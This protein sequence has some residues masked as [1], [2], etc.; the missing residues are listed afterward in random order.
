LASPVR[1]SFLPV[2]EAPDARVSRIYNIRDLPGDPVAKTPCSQ[3]K[4][5]GF[6]SWSGTRPHVQQLEFL[7]VE[8]KIEDP[9]GCDEDQAQPNK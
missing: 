3:C 7:N 1:G 9:I 8:M 2:S 4:G 5:P 6:H